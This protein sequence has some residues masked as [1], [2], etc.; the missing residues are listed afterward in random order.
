MPERD[1]GGCSIQWIGDAART[2]VNC[3]CGTPSHI[4][5]GSVKSKPSVGRPVVVMEVLPGYLIRRANSQNDRSTHVRCVTGAVPSDRSRSDGRFCQ[6]CN[7]LSF[8]ACL[9]TCSPPPTSVRCG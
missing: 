7:A 5:S 3:S 2:A 4:R 8:S 1:V 6:N 9:L